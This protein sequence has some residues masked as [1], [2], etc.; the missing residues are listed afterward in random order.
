MILHIIRPSSGA[1]GR[2]PHL[3]K[4]RVSL[5]SL[6]LMLSP[7]VKSCRHISE[8]HRLFLVGPTPIPC[9]TGWVTITG[10]SR[11]DTSFPSPNHVSLPDTIL[12]F[13][14]ARITPIFGT[15]IQYPAELVQSPC[16]RTNIEHDVIM[17]CNS[18]S[19]DHYG[20]RRIPS[21]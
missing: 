10:T 4:R 18:A 17:L 15:D 19:E 1:N 11:S 14:P 8:A 5:C 9:L 6:V 21:P 2:A 3:V 12:H 7:L 20:S 13:F 16:T